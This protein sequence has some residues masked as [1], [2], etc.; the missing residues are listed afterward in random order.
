MANEKEKLE[1]LNGDR[2][3][4]SESA[5]R[6]KHLKALVDGVGTE[7]TGDAAA[8]IR[9]LYAAINAMRVLLR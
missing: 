3:D 8:D 1:V 7:P 4:K 5:A 9:S 2:G 6:L